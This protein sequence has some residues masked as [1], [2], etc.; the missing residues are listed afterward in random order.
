MHKIWLIIKREYLT[1]V[2]KRTF[3]IGT[4]L[5]PILY[6][7]LIFGTGYIAEKTRQNLHVAIIDSS[8]YFTEA[9]LA[10]QNVIDNTS[11]LTLVKNDMPGKEFNYDSAGFDAYLVIP[12]LDWQKGE[13]SL[14]LKA[15]K[16]YISAHHMNYR[17]N[18]EIVNSRLDFSTGITELDIHNTKLTNVDLPS[19]LRII[20]MAKI[21]NKTIVYRILDK[22]DLT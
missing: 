1:R 16:S 7:A 20:D 11:T 9:L 15:K 22:Q 14:H 5:F 19:E 18:C 8:G 6:M 21:T 12:A 10:K 3:I 13:N 2:R 17:G 4:L